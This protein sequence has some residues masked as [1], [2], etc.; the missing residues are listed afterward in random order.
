[1][2]CFRDRTKCFVSI[3]RLRFYRHSNL[4]FLIERTFTHSR[5]VVVHV[6]MQTKKY[7]AYQREELTEKLQDVPV[8]SNKLI[9]L[10]TLLRV[11]HH[12]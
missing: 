11:L 1:M 10:L 2:P 3:V 9:K 4:Q 12:A 6:D 7:L 5:S 8:R